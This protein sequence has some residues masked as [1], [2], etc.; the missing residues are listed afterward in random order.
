MIDW[1]EALILGVVQGATEYLP[2]SS[3]G[4]LVI[5]Q[6]LFGL[7][8]PALLFDIIL[9]VGT[10]VAVLWYYRKDVGDLIRQSLVAIRGLMRGDSWS[11]VQKTYPSFRLAWLI[12]LGTIPTAFIGFMFQDTFEG[13]FASLGTVGYMLWITGL[14]LLIAHFSPQGNRRVGEMRPSDA[15]LIG[16]VQ[17]LAIAPGIS[18]SGATIAIALI[19]GIEKETAARYSFLLSVPSI[20]GALILRIGDAGSS[21]GVG[22]ASVGFLAALVTGYLCLALLVQ[23]VKR[24]KLAWFAPYCFAAGLFALIV[25]GKI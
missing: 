7:E 16:F 23:L 12:L 2:V 22:V 11:E 25:A 1:F 17:G 13:L 8:E 18:R 5:F 14:I 4:H 9:H 19:L 6:H 3:S 21:V 24:G 15:L 20:I 10:L